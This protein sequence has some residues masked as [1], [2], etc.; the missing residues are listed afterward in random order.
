[1]VLS[2]RAFLVVGLVLLVMGTTLPG[3]QANSKLPR[4]ARNRRAGVLCKSA[5][6]CGAGECC[7]QRLGRCLPLLT[8]GRFCRPITIQ[9]GFDCPCAVGLHCD[10][11]E[12]TKNLPIV[13]QRGACA[14]GEAHKEGA[15]ETS[16]KV[17]HVPRAGPVFRPGGGRR[18]PSKERVRHLIQKMAGAT[19]A[20]RRMPTSTGRRT[21]R[22]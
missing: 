11:L 13:V 9:R 20:G 4:L 10:L 19:A 21:W 12:E 16:E 6:D 1:M 22:G 15:K 7:P 3:A 5:A 17:N 14:V 18:V 2:F 8:E